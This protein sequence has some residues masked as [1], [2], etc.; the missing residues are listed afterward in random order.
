MIVQEKVVES[1]HQKKTIKEVFLCT[2][3]L[4]STIHLH[5]YSLFMHYRYEYIVLQLKEKVEMLEK[6][7][8]HVIREFDVE[9]TTIVKRSTDDNKHAV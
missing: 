8:S 7:L 1:K 2:Y 9:R 3:K 4:V 6:S 5:L